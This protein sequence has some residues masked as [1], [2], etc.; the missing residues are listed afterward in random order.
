MGYARGCAR[1]PGGC[2]T[3]LTGSACPLVF[4]RVF[5]G[6]GRV[7][8][9]PDDAVFVDA[10][11]QAIA[12]FT[13]LNAHHLNAT[14][15]NNRILAIVAGMCRQQDVALQ[16]FAGREGF[17]DYAIEALT[18][19]I[20]RFCPDRMPQAPAG[21]QYSPVEIDPPAPASIRAGPGCLIALR[22]FWSSPVKC[23]RH[24]GMP[25]PHHARLRPAVAAILCGNGSSCSGV[26]G[27]TAEI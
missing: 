21:Q 11:R 12:A 22:E 5:R 24:T 18:A 26:A 27:T 15:Q 13:L 25:V 8:C 19:D 14:S 3:C 23:A 9:V 20:D 2:E 6:R 7:A 10:A 1:L 17:L 16:P 4:D